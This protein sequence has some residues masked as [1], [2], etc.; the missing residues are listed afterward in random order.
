[1]TTSSAGFAFPVSTTDAAGGTGLGTSNSA[2]G[3]PAART[4]VPG[5]AAMSRVNAGAAA[6]DGSGAIAA[7]T[8][9]ATAIAFSGSA[10][11]NACVKYPSVGRRS[12]F[13]ATIRFTSVTHVL[14][15]RIA[16]KY[17]FHCRR[18]TSREK[19]NFER[20]SP[21]FTV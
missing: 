8:G 2:A 18:G 20:E 16:S 11:G 19:S 17:F 21:R 9:S 10:G 7:F 14:I 13:P 1:M 3:F 15:S 6:S 12:V 4:S 5:P